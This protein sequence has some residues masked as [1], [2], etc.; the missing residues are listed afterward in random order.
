MSNPL[1]STFDTLHG[2][3]PFGRIEPSHFLPAFEEAFSSGKAE[4][5]AIVN[6]RESP[7]F[8][9]TVA[10]LEAVGRPLSLLSALLFNLNHANTNDQIQ[11]LAREIS[12]RLARFSNDIWMNP[13]LFKRVKEVFSQRSSLDAGSDCLK[14]L[15]DTFKAFVRKG[16]LLEGH[17]AVRYRE[18]TEE[19]SALTLQFG[20]NVLAETNDFKLHITDERDVE[21]IPEG[22]KATAHAKALA[23]NKDGWIFTLQFPSYMPF[24]KHAVNRTLREKMFRAYSR[25]GNNGND[26]DNN[27]LVKKI[28]ALRIEKA[29][30]LGYNTYADY[31]LEE[32]MAESKDKVMAF[33]DELLQSSLPFAGDDVRD[34]AQL[35]A[36]DGIDTLQR[37]DFAY[38]GEKLKTARYKVNDEMTRPYFKLETVENGVFG[39]ANRLYGIS[40]R[41]TCEPD[42]YHP[43]VKVFEVID[44]DGSFL[45][46][47]Y[48]DYF[49]RPEKQGG[50]WMTS[51]RD[52]HREGDVDVRPHISIVTNF[53]PA[54]GDTPS[55]LTFN[56]VKTFLHE[57][58]HALHGMFSK[59]RFESQ[60]GTSV[61]RDFVELPSQ[62]MENWATEKQWLSDVAVHYI[63]GEPIPDEMI[64]NIIAAD[65]FQ[66]GY[67]TVRQLSFGLNDMAWHS[68]DA[69]SMLSVQDF[70]QQ[71]MAAT[72]LFPSVDGSCISTAFSHIFDGGYAAGYY[73]YKW[74]EVLDADAFE[75][76]KQNGVFSR[77]TASSFRR[78]I[79]EKGGSA[80]PMTLYKN[81][82]GSEPS[83]TPLLKRSGLVR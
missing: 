45:G 47:L 28:S 57:F 31:V 80:H 2:S 83:V 61:Y 27:E 14:L 77:E 66:S 29:R 35:A 20:E 25:R 49:P 59:V 41:Q 26:H 72:E 63:T 3:I 23:E 9:N 67:S 30:L 5:D 71:A 6:N 11:S 22:A 8:D 50:A 17:S 37:W 40:F 33:L 10:A 64:D 76:F 24:M 70:E 18:V 46:L 36:A 65:L 43:D 54:N 53:T 21:G 51:F 4:I 39:L 79:L 44:G 55:L 82:R 1:L 16:A 58:G 38:Y 19:L 81:F 52:Q 78:E 15:D 60:S 32:R 12:P 68:L 42:V 48:L 74:A 13:D 69:P 56:E 34:V 75:L 73:G 7:T 62:I